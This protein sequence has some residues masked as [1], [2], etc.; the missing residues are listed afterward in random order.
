MG[1]LGGDPMLGG[2]LMGDLGGDPLCCLGFYLV[3]DLGG[4]GGGM[5]A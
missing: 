5:G 4:G 1:D 3:G 2:D